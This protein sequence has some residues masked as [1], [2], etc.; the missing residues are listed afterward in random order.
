MGCFWDSLRFLWVS[1]RHVQ[2]VAEGSVSLSL[3]TSDTAQR[4]KESGQYSNKYQS[5]VIYVK[6]QDIWDEC[7]NCY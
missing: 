1:E 5:N 2:V 7:T 6:P 3:F 4:R